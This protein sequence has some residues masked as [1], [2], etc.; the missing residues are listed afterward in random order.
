MIR[1][2]G[3]V[4]EVEFRVL[5]PVGMLRAGKPVALGSR[6]TLALL[7]GLLLSANHVVS[8]DRLAEIVWGEQ[9]PARPR[10]ALHSAISRLRRLL[11]YDMVES[12]SSGY[13]LHADAGQLDLLRSDDLAATA[14]DAARRGADEQAAAALEEAVGLWRA[15][16]LGNVDSPAL[17]GEAARLIEKYLAMQEDRADLC[18]RLGRHAA[19]VAVLPPLVRAHPFRE[20]LVGQLM[21]ALSRGGRQADA[22]AAYE[23]LRHAL[24]EELGI[25]PGAWLQDVHIRIL[26]ADVDQ[27]AHLLARPELKHAAVTVAARDAQA[28][29]IVESGQP[30]GP[31]WRGRRPAP[32]G[33]VGRDDDIRALSE[34]TLSQRVVTLAGTAGVGKTSVALETAGRLAARFADGVAVVEL[35]TLPAQR[36]G[37]GPV[38]G[39]TGNGVAEIVGAV[40]L[41]LGIPAAPGQ[42]AEDALTEYL[43]KLELLLI[44]DNA[45]HV[46]SACGSAAE[47]IVR[48]CPRVRV[49]TTSRRLLGLSGEAVVEL[50]PLRPGPA[51]ELLRLRVAGYRP[52]PDLSADPARVAELCRL[53]EGLP[54]A[55]E[56]AAARLRTMSPG[57]LLERIG[58]QPS[59]LA[60]QDGP[61]LAH[62]R[63]LDATLRWSYNL[64]T[65]AG[66]LLL[67]RLA[68]FAGSF[69]LDSAEEVCGYSH[70]TRDDVAGLL[71]G[72]VDDC[73]VQAAR[74]RDGYAYRLLI[75]VRE[76]AL[77]Q[78]SPGDLV[79][80][81]GHHL[82]QL[83][84]MA[85]NCG[86]R[87]HGERPVRAVRPDNGE[88]R[89]DECLADITALE[90]GF[91]DLLAFSD[92]P[93]PSDLPALSGT[94]DFSDLLAAWDWA[95][96]DDAVR[97]EAELGARL[98][99]VAR[100]A[101]EPR[102]GAASGVLDY[103]MRAL[104]LPGLLPAPLVAHLTLL[105]GNLHYR[106]GDPGGA[107]QLIEQAVDLLERSDPGDSSRAR[108]AALSD[109]ALI[110]YGQAAADAPDVV[111]RSADA[112]RGTRDRKM[113]AVSLAKAAQMLA[114]LGHLCEA[115]GLIDEA[116]EAVG[117]D[118]ALRR[119][120]LPRRS[121]VRL[122][123]GRVAEA[124]RDTQQVLA[125]LDGATSYERV[126]TLLAHG[127]AQALDGDSEA[128]LVTLGEGFTLA[129]Q[130]QVLVLLPGFFLAL[131]YVRRAG[132]QPDEAVRLVCDALRLA[133]SHHDLLTG[134][135][136][137]HLA[138]A[139]ASDT[140]SPYA[141]RIAAAVRECRLRGGLPVW[142]LTE[143]EYATYEKELGV[144]SAPAPAGR[145]EPSVFVAAAELTLTHLARP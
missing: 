119:H 145:L 74:D 22:L 126:S 75:P 52:G 129:R 9:Q 50:A 116:G 130:R 27:G 124:R 35:G 76:F 11:G 68:V 66:R 86:R 63:G 106:L 82:R 58:S 85:Q 13:R 37:T 102:P 53:I 109:L 46:A 80:A 92:L 136:A 91:S 100:P 21:L 23:S 24:R 18:L 144:D 30:G 89:G 2:G 122:H 39:V 121:S 33:L 44:L 96:R 133:L 114:Q 132:G 140:G 64:L 99:L 117:D 1:S 55:V 5:G 51:A 115:M 81:R 104:S 93:V 70:L 77:A 3:L 79:A 49:L 137:L 7:A 57:T 42:R 131:A 28:T 36:P 61:G 125:E 60:A 8:M 110:A 87:G 103:V 135:N 47:L 16:L 128:A 69:T 143:H 120:Y 32:E 94:P 15:P 41:A 6:T 26:R 123:A 71:S 112:A 97:A 65:E 31:R 108:V 83:H 29:V 17:H 78:A 54:L 4:S 10:A 84:E 118:R 59:I 98:L 127:W 107:R 67:C 73:L 25:D 139:L 142:P 134:I 38:S 111:R 43:R 34:T 45:E 40:C 19:V 12:L 48:S 95:L 20:R 141:T 62:Q 90:H 14:G 113:I 101:W 138:T 105:A 72:L 56:L 88:G